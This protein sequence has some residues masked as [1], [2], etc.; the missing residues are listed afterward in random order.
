MAGCIVLLPL[1]VVYSL[2]DGLCV[3]AGERVDLKYALT[4]LY[5]QYKVRTLFSSKLWR[6]LKGEKKKKSP[7]VLVVSA[8][9]L[10]FSLKE[11]E[12]EGRK[13]SCKPFILP[14]LLRE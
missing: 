4:K 9:E 14:L 12:V 6:I 3:H 11:G 13:V 7:N 5:G 1:V 10:E 8:S 2:G